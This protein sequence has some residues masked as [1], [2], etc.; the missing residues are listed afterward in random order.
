MVACANFARGRPG[1]QQLR[2]F[3]LLAG[4]PGSLAE[5]CS[6]LRS[7]GTMGRGRA[8]GGYSNVYLTTSAGQRCFPPDTV[9]HSTHH[10]MKT[11]HLFL[12]VLFA[13]L[14]CQAQPLPP[15]P[16]HSPAD[17]AKEPV[18]YVIRVEWHETGADSKFLE[19]LTTEGQFELN[20]IQKNSVKI[21]NS[22]VPVTLKFSG[23]LTAVDEEKG[24]LQLYLGRTVPYV[25]GSMGMSQS[26]SQM[27]VGLTSTFVVK[28]GKAQVIQSDENGDISVLVKQAEK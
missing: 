11:L 24:R 3:H 4:F 6:A 7:T 15:A 18:N 19:V 28:F 27:S 8:G 5:Q 13:A 17:P 1:A 23:S 26:Y 10:T 22:E 25:T 21:N 14:V 2:N 16:P 9:N 12:V 20:T